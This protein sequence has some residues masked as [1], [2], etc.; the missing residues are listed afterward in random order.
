MA[1][2]IGN[3]TISFALYH[4]KGRI[5]TW[6]F[7]TAEHTVANEYV[8][9]LKE[10]L[11]EMDLTPAHVT[12]A[13]VASVVPNKTAIIITCCRQLFNVEPMRIGASEVEHNL[14]VILD[15]PLEV[16]A[17]R[18]AN[19]VAAMALC[20][21]NTP[22]LIV[23][24]STAVVFDVINEKNQYVGGTI[25]PGF[26]ISMDALAKKAAKLPNVELNQPDN[27]I[28]TN[29]VDALQS[30]LFW[31]YSSLVEGMIQRIETEFGTKLYKIAT[32]HLTGFISHTINM[33]DVIN[34][35]L[36]LDGINAIYHYNQKNK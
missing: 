16:G 32:G 33:F 24:F 22:F 3:T 17:D 28:G 27:I 2:D 20:Q 13:A 5:K 21:N 12:G 6:R 10:V 31:G 4:E 18:I 25:V 29:T 19:A 11:S 9:W 7:D 14:E 23:D 35:N 26:E 15:N 1:I 8:F 30:G 34:P 36:T